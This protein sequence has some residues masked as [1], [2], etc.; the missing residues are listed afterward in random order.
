MLQ[1][2]IQGS[3]MAKR[4]EHYIPQF[5]LRGFCGETGLVHCFDKRTG[6]PYAAS[7]RNIASEKGFYDVELDSGKTI[8]FEVCFTRLEEAAAPVIERI[9]KTG[10]LVISADERVSLA[11]YLAAQMVRTPKHRKMI[12][13]FGREL[14]TKFGDVGE[15]MDSEA[16]ARSALFDVFSQ[17]EEF[18]PHLCNKDW[19]LL[20]APPGWSFLLG[21]DPVVLQNTS[22][23]SSLHRG[24]LGI[25]VDGIEIYHPLSPDL[26]LSLNCKSIGEI[27]RGGI[28]KH[29]FLRQMGLDLP[30]TEGT[31]FSHE[32][33]NRL[34]TGTPLQ[35]SKDNV[36]NVNF[37]QCF[38]SARFIFSANGDFT[39]IK[40]CL[41]RGDVSLGSPGI[42]LNWK[43]IGEGD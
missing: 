43:V 30:F 34:A 29:E 36:D 27:V 38:Q 22:N 1:V 15:V 5:L 31:R 28:L 20:R 41:S 3:Q 14:A 32:Y 9:R 35:M 4:N 17:I 10:Q 7:T 42:M 40:D 25:G 13:A 23:P 2:H 12:A 37:M 6:R 26:C 33:V 19:L 11:C 24:T 21:D 16:K 39:F 8:N 18:S